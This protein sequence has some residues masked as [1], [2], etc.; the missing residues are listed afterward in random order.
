MSA[1]LPAGFTLRP[2]VMA[3]G[4]GLVEMSNEETMALI[5]VPLADLDW[6]TLPWTAPGV[7]LE[8]DFAV[9]EGPGGDLAGYLMIDWHVNEGEV[10]ALGIVAVR[11]HGQGLG[12]AMVREAERRAHLLAGTIEP[13]RRV[14]MRIGALADEPRVSELLASL[15]YRE[16][17][18][19]W[20]MS[21]AFDRPPQPPA[22]VEGIELRPFAA[23]DERAAAAAMAEA[24]ADHWGPEGSQDEWLH[25]HIEASETFDPAL[26][27]L[28]WEGESLAGVLVGEAPSTEDPALGYVA[29][30]GVR[31]AFRSRGI[32]EAMLRD[33]FVKLHGRGMAGAYLYVDSES[34][35]GATR[36]Y[37]RIGMSSQ[38]RFA[39]WE[40]ELRPGR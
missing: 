7:N 40:K 28:A 39:T 30:L 23:G 10:F 36:L 34:L 14:V 29:E 20:R 38:P 33:A 31:R 4:P 35:T 5:G 17:R 15:G 3:D 2:P 16:V 32:G 11:F 6:F 26:W 22:A 21:I 19:F 12:T 1:E 25:S 24:F 13:E 18:R 9:F 27:T 37:E 8:R